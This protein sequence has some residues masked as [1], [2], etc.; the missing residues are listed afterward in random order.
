ML[1]FRPLAILVGLIG[2]GATALAADPP[3]L[4]SDPVTGEKFDPARSRLVG[5]WTGRVLKV[6][7][8]DAGSLT[9]RVEQV[10]QVPRPGVRYPVAQRVAQDV[11][12]PLAKNVIVRQMTLPPAVNDAGKPRQR[13]A[14]ELRKLK[15]TGNLPGYAA[16]FSQLRPDDVVRVQ[17]VQPKPPKGAKPGDPAPKPLAVLVVILSEAPAKK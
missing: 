3:A 9:L 7:A 11:E 15:G 14:E 17:L 5:D 6:S 12:Y 16:E 10:T 1:V 8:G 13:T 4:P 2:V